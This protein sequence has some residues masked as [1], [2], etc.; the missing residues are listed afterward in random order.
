M[1]ALPFVQMLT[2]FEVQMNKKICY[3]C[4]VYG[5]IDESVSCERGDDHFSDRI[6]G[7]KHN[8]HSS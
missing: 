3:L 2:N 1:H 6:A 4:E 7:V 8:L 5:Q